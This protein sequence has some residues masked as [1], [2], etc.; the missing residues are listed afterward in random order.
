MLVYQRLAQLV[1]AWKRC[2]EKQ[3]TEWMDKHEGAIIELAK[4][5]LPCGSGFDSGS[6][7]DLSAS[8][9]NKLVI[10]TSY[11][12]MD[13]NGFYDGWT[14]HNVIV[15]PS[16]AF[17]FDLRITGKDRDGWKDYAYECFDYA[18]RQEVE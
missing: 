2:E 14:E 15:K 10:W 8:K 6:R 12:H 16:L 9:P 17:D 4:N 1:D 18:L 5:Y 7:V 3:N 13:E 11:H